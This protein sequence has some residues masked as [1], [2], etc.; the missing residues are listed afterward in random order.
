MSYYNIMTLSAKNMVANGAFDIVKNRDGNWRVVYK[1]NLSDGNIIGRNVILNEKA[2]YDN[3]LFYQIRKCLANEMEDDEDLLRQKLIFIDFKE[4]KTNVFNDIDE[5][6]IYDD[7]R[8]KT[9]AEL[10]GDKGFGYRLRWLFDPCNGVQISFD[11]KTWIT[12]VP[13]DKSNSMARDSRISYIDKDLKAQLDRRLLLDIDFSKIKVIFSKFYSY[14]G[15]YLSTGY[16]IVPTE[17]V[18]DSFVLNQDTVIVLPD[19]ENS[20]T[21]VLYSGKNIKTSTDPLYRFSQLRETKALNSFD[22][23]GLICPQYASYI[24]EQLSKNYG[25]VRKSTTFQVRMPFIKGVLHEVDFHAFLDEQF[26]NNINWNKDM[27]FIIEDI[28]GQKRDIRKAKIIL[29]KSMFKCWE[30]L[31]RWQTICNIEDPMQYY[32]EKIKKYIHTLYVTNMDAMFTNVGSI[33]LNYQFLC[34]LDIDAVSFDSMIRWNV[35]HIKQIPQLLIKNNKYIAKLDEPDLIETICDEDDLILVDDANNAREKCLKALAC[36]KAFINEPRI[37]EIIKEEQARLAKNLC[38]GRLDVAGEQRFLSCD[39]LELLRSIC[40]EIKNIEFNSERND[41]LWKQRLYSNHFYMP[42]KKIHLKTYRYYGLLRNPHLSRNEQCILRPYV[43]TGS[44]HDKYFSHLKG[45]VMLSVDSLAPMALGGADFD[46]DLVKIICDKRVVQA[47]KSSYKINKKD[48]KN[49]CERDLAVVSIPSPG[50]G[51]QGFDSGSI[52]FKTIK[53]TFSN[54]IGLI[55]NY[56]VKIAQ[57]EYKYNKKKSPEKNKSRELSPDENKG[58]CCAGCTVITGLEIDS[59]KTGVHPKANMRILSDGI[60]KEAEKEYVFLDVKK[61]LK[62]IKYRYY[63][64]WVSEDKKGKTLSMYLTKRSRDNGNSK[65]AWLT[66]IPVFDCSCGVANIDRLPGEYLKYLK[67]YEETKMARN[68]KCLSPTENLCFKFET[69]G[70]WNACLDETKKK[71]VLQLVQAYLK[72]KSLAWKVQ[73]LR[74]R[75]EEKSGKWCS[76]IYHLLNVQYDDVHQKLACGAEVEEALVQAYTEIQPLFNDSSIKVKDAIE[77]LVQEKWYYLTK[78][79]CIN[80]IPTIL[81]LGKE[82]PFSISPPVM[83]LFTNFRNK[84]FMLFYYFLNDIK[85]IFEMDIDADTYIMNE[86]LK[87]EPKFV[88]LHDNVYF[89]KLLSTYTDYSD[90]KKDHKKTIVN[91]CRKDLSSIFSKDIDEALKYVFALP[92]KYHGFLWEI[93]TESEILRNIYIPE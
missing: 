45:I 37:K 24:N 67:T 33:S 53:D 36:N 68:K 49:E 47:I 25:I 92:K 91:M 39:L 44:L 55:S 50:G 66:Q 43:K 28:Y 40:C 12:F 73:R 75:S 62:E 26:S 69:E 9:E 29:T 6:E 31:K 21:G 30:W 46:G 85:S 52:P 74:E 90:K 38:I 10:K 63:T 60:A 35:D 71:E 82:T 19:R 23:E 8:G 57:K 15:L 2:H 54:N 48:T 22:G 72:I 56:A 51:L 42:E 87:A 61:R 80:K 34:T 58:F 1:Y 77:R 11:G 20:V 27:A 32:F 14:R 4:D 78:E 64:P 83:E 13:F 93:F 86:E 5:D 59:A 76:Y 7:Y 16:R 70:K 89:E 41:E 17:N 88:V 65:K 79:E 18:D 81:D 3:A 84:G